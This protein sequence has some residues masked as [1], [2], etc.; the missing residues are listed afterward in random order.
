MLAKIRLV[1]LFC[2]VLNLSCIECALFGLSIQNFLNQKS[3]KPVERKL[4]DDYIN[5]RLNIQARMLSNTV[6][7]PS[8]LKLYR[9][10]RYVNYLM[11][12][13]AHQKLVN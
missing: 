9:N 11:D 6:N 13:R 1:I 5:G 2:L 7:G 12:R 10:S 4:S 8:P 3:L